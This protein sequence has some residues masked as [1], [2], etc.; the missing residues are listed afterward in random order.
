MEKAQATYQA[1]NI[2][3]LILQHQPSAIPNIVSNDGENVAKE[4]L[5]LRKAL[6]SGLQSQE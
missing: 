1:D 2:I 4:I 6:I 5:A 3:A